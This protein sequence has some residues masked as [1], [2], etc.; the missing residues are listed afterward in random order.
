MLTM[1]LGI[2]TIA[3]VISFK[4]INM[5]TSIFGLVSCVAMYKTSELDEDKS[6]YWLHIIVSAEVCYVEVAKQR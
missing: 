4:S 3:K 6:I 1:V 2:N 5:L